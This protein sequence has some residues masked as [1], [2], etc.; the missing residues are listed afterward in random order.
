[1]VLEHGNDLVNGFLGGM[2]PTLAFPD[3]LRV[4]AALG[5][6]SKDP[7]VSLPDRYTEHAK[8]WL[9]AIDSSRGMVLNRQQ[10]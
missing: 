5:N 7:C 6:Y 3:L 2:A 9:G 4:A 8:P 10:V 1:V